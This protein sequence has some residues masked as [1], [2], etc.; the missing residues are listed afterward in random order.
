MARLAE[1]L[2]IDVLQT[3]TVNAITEFSTYCTSIVARNADNQIAHVRNL[4]FQA[5]SL[6]KQLVFEAVL[7]KDGEERARSPCIGGYYGSF[8]GHKPNR[9][10][11]S[12]NV[13]ETVVIPSDE[14]LI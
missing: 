4:D 1:V 10:S 11:V 13:R 7:V 8:T 12:Y 5:T 9:F 2:E 6:M 3:V 14:T